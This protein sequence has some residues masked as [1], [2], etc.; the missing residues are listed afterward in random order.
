M[1][2]RSYNLVEITSS[3]ESNINELKNILN[4]S[5]QSY[6]SPKGKNVNIQVE[7]KY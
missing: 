7:G 3:T 6:K 4:G 1:K 5:R 2:Y